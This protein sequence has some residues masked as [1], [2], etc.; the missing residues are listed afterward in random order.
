MPISRDQ[1]I[2]PEMAKPL[3]SCLA[4]SFASTKPLA[5]GHEQIVAVEFSLDVMLPPYPGTSSIR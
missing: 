3:S 2:P 5:S 4:A 1:A